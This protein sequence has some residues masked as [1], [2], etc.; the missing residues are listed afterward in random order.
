M[1]IVHAG[2]VYTA[3]ASQ[4]DSGWGNL[5]GTPRLTVPSAVRG[6]GTRVSFDAT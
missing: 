1:E 6:I 3:L 5:P 4:N 2:M